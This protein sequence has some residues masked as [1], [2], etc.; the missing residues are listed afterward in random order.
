MSTQIALSILR[1]CTQPRLSFLARTTHPHNFQ[2]SA[3]RFDEKIL[4]CFREIMK[5][6]KE[7]KVKNV[8]QEEIETQIS[9]PI[10]AGGFGLRPMTRISHAAYFASLT[11]ILPDFIQSFPSSRIPDIDYS[12]TNVHHE[13]SYCRDHLQQHSLKPQP[14]PSPPRKKTGGRAGSIIITPSIPQRRSSQHSSQQTSIS[15][16]LIQQILYGDI[17]NLWKLAQKYLDDKDTKGFLEIASIQHEATNQIED[18]IFKQLH[19]TSIPYRQAL[20]TSLTAP[21]SSSW[22]NVLPTQPTYT[23]PNESIRLATRHR[24]GLLP[25][26]SLE[27]EKCA[28]RF[29]TR[30]IDDPDHFQSCEKFRRTYHTMRHN[31]IVQVVQDLAISVGFMAIREPNGH[32]R[33]DEI[34]N[35]PSSSDGYN[36]HGDLLLLKHD[37]KL[38][39]DV[40][41]CRPTAAHHFKSH[42][43]VFDTPLYSTII[44]T[45]LK[46]KKY[47]EIAKVNDYRL[48]AFSMETYGGLGLESE[49][50]LHLLASHSKEYTPSEFLRHAYRRLACTLQSSNANIPLLAI[51]QLHLHRHSLKIE[52]FGQRNFRGKQDSFG[53]AQPIN[54]DQLRKSLEPELSLSEGRRNYQ[55]NENDEEGNSESTPTFIHDNQ[56]GFADYQIIDDHYSEVDLN[57]RNYEVEVI[58]DTN[59]DIGITIAA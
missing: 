22:I 15:S 18:L 52:K 29:S 13:L 49:K 20:L 44:A 37:M 27:H 30:F 5:L 12:Q 10:K 16:P 8:T 46:H 35:L 38:Y 45:K 4:N 41:I 34:A 25:F 57:D 40:V 33:P 39:I 1:Y 11:T 56:I 36:I 53:Y 19:Q 3:K 51:Q 26:D 55:Q 6:Q 59:I 17:L 42:P 47:D 24:L 54:S 28:C 43:R 58:S 50:L 23:I 32:I 2:P 21:H 48:F 9:L 31:N 14:K 7:T